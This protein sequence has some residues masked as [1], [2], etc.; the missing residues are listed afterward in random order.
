VPTIM[1]AQPWLPQLPAEQA[2]QARKLRQTTTQ[3][4]TTYLKRRTKQLPLQEL[5]PAEQT[6]QRLVHDEQTVIEAAER[7]AR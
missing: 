3:T 6:Y 7:A 1:F 5:K 2:P 4:V